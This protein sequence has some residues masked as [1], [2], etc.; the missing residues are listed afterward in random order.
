[1]EFFGRISYI[2]G[3]I[4][5]AD[6]LSTVSPAYAREIQTPEYGFGLDG[7]LLARAEVLTGILNGADYRQWNPETDP[8]IPVRHS[9]GD[10]GRRP[11]CKRQMVEEFGLPPDA[12]DS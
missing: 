5:F 10:L 4:E 11:N 8:L 2:K 12:I 9:A 7:E 3:G 1:M 6:A